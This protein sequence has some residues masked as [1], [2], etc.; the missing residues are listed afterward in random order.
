MPSERRNV[1]S[2]PFVQRQSAEES[3][4]LRPAAGAEKTYD[5]PSA[6]AD[7]GS[8]QPD[9]APFI[10]QGPGCGC[11]GPLAVFDFGLGNAV[12]DVQLELDETLRRRRIAARNR[13]SAGSHLGAVASPPFDEPTGGTAAATWP[14]SRFSASA[15]ITEKLGN[16]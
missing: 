7:G 11:F 12:W 14:R 5:P 8:P 3:V 10:G 15:K 9:E 6:S 13:D 4:K 2:H 16:G 1:R